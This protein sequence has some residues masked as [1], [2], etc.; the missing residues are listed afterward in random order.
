MNEWIKDISIDDLPDRYREMAEIIGVENTLLL[1][2]HYA[3]MSFY[4]AGL[5][6]LIAKK[7]AKYIKKNFNGN[8]HK[9]LA[10]ETGY[11][12]RW[13][14]EILKNSLDVKQ[15]LIFTDV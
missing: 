1:A 13:I 6:S 10:R 2:Q 4:F 7:K 12:E 8:N 9:E 14:Y 11:S 15:G 5:D 3:K